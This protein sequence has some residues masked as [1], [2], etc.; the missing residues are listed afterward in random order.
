MSVCMKVCTS[1]IATMKRGGGNM[2]TRWG[3]NKKAG[4]DNSGPETWQAY[5]ST[6]TILV[7]NDNQT[8]TM[9][10]ALPHTTLGSVVHRTL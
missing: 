7:I 9:S 4:R 5:G 3:R 1:S 6:E 10:V 8:A 2:G